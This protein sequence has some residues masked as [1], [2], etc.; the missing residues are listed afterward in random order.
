MRVY[1]LLIVLISYW[2]GIMC[3]FCVSRLMNLNALCYAFNVY[4]IYLL[5]S[6]HQQIMELLL[7]CLDENYYL[8]YLR[9]SCITTLCVP[10][11][12]IN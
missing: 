8:N 5:L 2:E 10:S 11:G 4:N 3:C 6:W 7:L 1:I 12:A 9:S